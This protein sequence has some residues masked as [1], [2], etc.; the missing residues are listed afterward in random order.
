MPERHLL[1]KVG[2]II[3]LIWN[4]KTQSGLC[5]ETRLIV[6]ELHENI[7]VAKTIT[8]KHI[9]TKNETGTIWY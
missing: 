6:K 1:L 2:S 4:L 9:N 8:V 7:I 5:N 3:I